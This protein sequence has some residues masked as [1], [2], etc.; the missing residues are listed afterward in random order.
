MGKNADYLAGNGTKLI[1]IGGTPGKGGRF[2]LLL[3]F[4]CVCVC[5]CVCERERE[6]ERE[7]VCVC[8]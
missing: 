6:R 3:L 5:V 1:E 2:V 7:Y 8:V 4:V